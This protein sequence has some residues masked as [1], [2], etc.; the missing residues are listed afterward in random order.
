MWMINYVQEEIREWEIFVTIYD[1][2]FEK[3]DVNISEQVNFLGIIFENMDKMKIEHHGN[4]ME[5]SLEFFIMG[6][7]KESSN[8]LRAGFNLQT[9]REE[10]FLGLAIPYQKLV[11]G[12]LHLSNTTGTDV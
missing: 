7:C 4:M 3:S 1:N 9:G 8:P 10:K 12:F 5:R 11:G 2:I 6:D